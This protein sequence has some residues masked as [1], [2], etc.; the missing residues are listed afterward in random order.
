MFAAGL[1]V[2][3]QQWLA[4]LTSIVLLSCLQIFLAHLVACRL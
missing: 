3:A 1:A 4:V 2:S